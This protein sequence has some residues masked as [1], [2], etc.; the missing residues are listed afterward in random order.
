LPEVIRADGAATLLFLPLAHVF[1]RFIQVVC[2]QAGARMGHTP[3]PSTVLEDLAGFRPTFLLSVPRVFE[4]IYNSAEQKAHSGGK[5]RIFRWAAGVADRYSRA[6]DSGR[7]GL[8]LRG[9][10]AL[11]DRLVFARFRAAMGGQVSYA[12]SGGA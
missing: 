11:A 5:G 3:D 12:I 9:Q 2:L 10:H 8:A 4:K 6:L 7:P 1:A